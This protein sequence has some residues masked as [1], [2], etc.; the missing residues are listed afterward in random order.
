MNSPIRSIQVVA[1]AIVVSCSMLWAADGIITRSPDASGQSCHLKFPAISEETLFTANPQL[2]DPKDG[3]VIDFYGPCNH[4]PLGKVEVTRQR[5]DYR[6]YR[7]RFDGET[8]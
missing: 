6:R 2:K 7:N 5:D 1:G 3:D 8:D 4:D